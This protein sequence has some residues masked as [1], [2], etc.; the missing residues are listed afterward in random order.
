MHPSL[1]Y[2]EGVTPL[3]NPGLYRGLDKTAHA[4]DR[5]VPSLPENTRARWPGGLTCG[6]ALRA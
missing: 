4:T 2:V 5:P 6:S 3:P 1:I